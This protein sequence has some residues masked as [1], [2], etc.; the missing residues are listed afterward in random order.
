HLSTEPSDETL[1]RL[2]GQIVQDITTVQTQP[3]VLFF[4]T[5]E[6]ASDAIFAWLERRILLPLIET[7]STIETNPTVAVL[8]SR[9]MLRW[10]QYV[11]RRK[12]E[13]VELKPLDNEATLQQ[14]FPPK[15]RNDD[16]SERAKHIYD[17]TFGHPLSTEYLVE[18]RKATEQNE[19]DSESRKAVVTHLLERANVPE[20]IR[21]VVETIA[22]FRDFDIH[23][24]RDV[25]PTCIP[26]R[27]KDR[28]QADFYNLLKQ[29]LE[30]HLIAW[31]NDRHAYVMDETI[32]KIIE[33]GLRVYD[34]DYYAKVN[35][36]ACSYYGNLVTAARTDDRR[37]EFLQGYLFHLIQFAAM[38]DLPAPATSTETNP[39]QPKVQERLTANFK[40]VPNET[41]KAWWQHFSEVSAKLP[42]Q[43][44]SP[45]NPNRLSIS[46]SEQTESDA[47]LR[48]VWEDLC[49]I[50]EAE[51]RAFFDPPPAMSDT[52][53]QGM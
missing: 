44:H 46:R 52:E 4:D 14:V 40:D 53:S 37:V 27:Y 22:L 13:P 8:A 43:P 45:L 25:L 48:S 29:L 10:R 47:T 32:R 5:C 6:Q 28:S 36:A 33:F 30:T 51:L 15:P 41:R 31:D 11:V 42:E 35:T 39:P 19:V 1:D 49:T 24:L 21:R 50:I 34:V 26:D 17:I 3:V 20:D 12:V 7:N 18:K 16:E 9:S 38:P 2:V 23:T